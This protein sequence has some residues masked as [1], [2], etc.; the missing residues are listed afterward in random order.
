M[1]STLPLNSDRQM[2]E[3]EL[4]IF[5]EWGSRPLQTNS[6][7][8]LGLN[9]QGQGQAR[10]QAQSQRQNQPQTQTQNPR[11]NPGQAQDFRQNQGQPQGHGST[12]VENSLNRSVSANANPQRQKSQGQSQSYGT[13]NQKSVNRNMSASATFP[14]QMSQNQAHGQSQP[15]GHGMINANTSVNRSTSASVN[16]NINT[17]RQASH[18]QIQPQGQR[19]A[20]ESH[21][22]VSSNDTNNDT[23]NAN[24]NANTSSQTQKSQNTRGRRHGGRNKHR[25]RAPTVFDEWKAQA[26]KEHEADV[27]KN[28]RRIPIA[29]AATAT[30]TANDT[31]RLKNVWDEWM[32]GAAGGEGEAGDTIPNAPVDTA[33]ARNEARTDVVATVSALV[34]S[35]SNQLDPPEDPKGCSKWNRKTFH[36]HKKSGVGPIEAVAKETE[37]VVAGDT[38][39]AAPVSSAETQ[40][41]SQAA[42][43]NTVPAA[44]IEAAKGRS[45][46]GRSRKDS[47]GHRSKSGSVSA[48]TRAHKEG[49]ISANTPANIP[50]VYA[51]SLTMQHSERQPTVDQHAAGVSLEPEGCSLGQESNSKN[52]LSPEGSGS[53]KKLYALTKESTAGS[54]YLVDSPTSDISTTYAVP[55]SEGPKNIARPKDEAN[56]QSNP[57]SESPSNGGLKL[58]TIREDTMPPVSVEAISS[59]KHFNGQHAAGQA[60]VRPASDPKK[61][62]KKLKPDVV[63]D[64]RQRS[65]TAPARSASEGVARN[66]EQGTAASTSPSAGSSGTPVNP[67]S[68][69]AAATDSHSTPS[70]NRR[71][72]RAYQGSRYAL[73]G[74]NP[75]KT[76]IKD[77]SIT[78]S[79]SATAEFP[80]PPVDPG[81]SLPERQTIGARENG[82]ASQQRSTPRD[83]CS[84]QGSF[85]PATPENASKATMN[86]KANTAVASAGLPA[87]SKPHNSFTNQAKDR[88]SINDEPKAAMNSSEGRE[89]KPSHSRQRSTES[90]STGKCKVSIKSFSWGAH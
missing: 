72:S 11:Q 12:N 52:S 6:S 10:A 2:S 68:D 78:V 16:S 44:S 20:T 76:G 14:R 45:Q 33:I 27:D 9:S 25:N 57:S 28:K 55:A 65:D 70:N 7:S 51:I 79:T 40:Q 60:S 30:A 31:D 90:T 73:H 34:D 84:L 47:H 87:S 42:T 22:A 81:T 4:R 37:D 58:A 49:S 80:K 36:G 83:F 56:S 13:S 89:R 17:P 53:P 82:S 23:N 67:T 21:G 86:N 35:A 38:T 43:D 74:D 71:D 64:M 88:T 48:G 32:A 5:E 24:S 85:V 62:E 61:A 77:S 50:P 3:R 8:S 54:A 29:T 69:S 46:T 75:K 59:V 19:R 66:K 18:N 41:N 15:Q 39:S 63:G 26:T 1:T